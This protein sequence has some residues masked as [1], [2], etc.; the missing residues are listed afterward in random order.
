MRTPPWP[1]DS[2]DHLADALREQ[3]ATSEE[4]ADL[5]PALRHLAEWQ[6]PQ[7]TTADTQ[8]LLSQLMPYLPGVSPVRQVIRTRRISQRG[9]LG[10]LLEIA[11]TQVSIFNPAFWLLSAAVMLAGAAAILEGVPLD[12]SLL[13]RTIAPFLAYLGTTIAFRGASLRVLEFELACPPSPVQLAFARMV[14]VLGYDVT[15]GLLLSLALWAHG[16]ASFLTLTLYW[17]MPL[18]LV[19][20]L[21]MLLSLHLPVQTASAISYGGWLML[22]VIDTTSKLQAL[23]LTPLTEVLLGGVGLALL[24]I[25]LQRLRAS[26]PRLLPHS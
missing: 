26:V 5:V 22:L 4:V 24:A 14:I 23:P 25:A 11:R 7:P 20:G 8:R 21:A 16:A 2:A 12:Q 15:L 1:L 10:A 18:L 19:A 9:K 6:A 17:L 3:H 13:L